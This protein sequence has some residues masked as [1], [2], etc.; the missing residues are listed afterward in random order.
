MGKKVFQKS[1]SAFFE[2]LKFEFFFVSEVYFHSSPFKF[3]LFFLF[4]LF[5]LLFSYPILIK[6]E[7]VL[8][9]YN[10]GEVLV[11]YRFNVGVVCEFFYEFFML[12]LAKRDREQVDHPCFLT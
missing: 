2:H 5:F 8:S 3:M 7:N 6:S 12:I 4:F 10:M 1:L 11:F 9:F